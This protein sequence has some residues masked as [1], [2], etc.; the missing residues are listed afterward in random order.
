MPERYEFGLDTFGDVT[1]G[2]D[3]GPLPHAQ[4]LRNVVEEAVLADRLGLDFFGVG[5]H[6]RADFAV[7]APEVVLAA[8]AGRTERIHLGSAVTVLSS[9]D[10]VRVFQR[11]ATLDGLS[12]G[13][14]EV[15]LGRG[16][17]TESFPLF[18]FELNQY[19]ELFE[20]KLALF[21]GLLP[22]QPVTWAGKLRPPL[23]EQSV[24]PPVEHGRLKTW[25][26]VGG[27]PESVVRA[28]H[29]GLPLVLAI[30][31]GSPARFA[32]LADLYRR[33][34]EQFGNPLQPIAVHSPGFIAETDAEALDTL[35]PHYE[36]IIGR[37]G[38]ERG[39]G[40]V[41]REHFEDEAGPNG[42]LYA[43]SPENV[44]TKIAAAMR[45]IGATRF[46]LK[47]SNGGLPHEVMMRSI[48][49]YA[50]E[51]VPRV[52]ELLAAADAEDA[53]LSAVADLGAADRADAAAAA[54]LP[55]D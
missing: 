26:G 19:Q 4:V 24:F 32:P 34:L 6:H 42:A 20:E 8:I 37:I 38:R 11:F 47:Y 22:Q 10:P 18:G 53:E 13:R 28:A 16:S 46:D 41:S 5:E 14:A 29:Y 40:P 17:F 48:E 25:I 49:L 7:S 45:A 52:R 43:G 23:T 1:V 55:R 21:A 39:W 44:A 12:N 30:I 33:A 2:P 27:S 3:G 31:G 54:D 15:I 51:V 50:T 9:D 35:W 36:I